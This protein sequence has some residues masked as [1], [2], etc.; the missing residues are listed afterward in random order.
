MKKAIYVYNTLSGRG[1]DDRR[2]QLI[3]KNLNKTYDDVLILKTNT[4]EELENASIKASEEKRDFIFSGGDGTFNQVVNVIMKLNEKPTLGYLPTGTTN[5]TAKNFLISRNIRKALKV[6]ANQQSVKFD[7]CLANDEKYFTYVA[8]LGA[9]ADIA[10][11]TKRKAKKKIGNLAYYRKAFLEAFK[12]RRIHVLVKTKDE[13][14][15]CDVP[16]I[17][18]LNGRSVASFKIGKRDELFDHKFHVYLTRPGPFNG[19][20]H[21]LFFK[22]K[23]YKIVT[24]EIFLEAKNTEDDWCLDGERGNKGKLHIKTIPKALSIYVNPRLIKRMNK[25]PK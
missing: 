19:L 25:R 23:T 22:I 4:I 11:V 6:I 24:D 15:A 8:A 17:L 5:D 21:Y 14:F 10:Y 18:V 7:L 16:F 1:I 12:P 3:E 9:F 13:T 2:L 20:L